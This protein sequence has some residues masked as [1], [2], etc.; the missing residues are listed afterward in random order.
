MI[1]LEKL[2]AHKDKCNVRPVSSVMYV[3]NL[4]TPFCVSRR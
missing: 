1:S 3:H 2:L 4:I